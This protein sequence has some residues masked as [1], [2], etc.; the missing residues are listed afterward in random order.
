MEPRPNYWLNFLEDVVAKSDYKNEEN[1]E[2]DYPTFQIREVHYAPRLCQSVAST[3]RSIHKHKRVCW[4][5]ARLRHQY[6]PVVGESQTHARLRL[7]P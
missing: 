6:R 2:S 3:T 4:G 1:T 5:A 7:S